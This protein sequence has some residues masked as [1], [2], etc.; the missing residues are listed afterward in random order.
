[1]IRPN[2]RL[3]FTASDMDFI[4]SVLGA[5]KDSSEHLRKLF[6]DPESLDAI[7]DDKRLLQQI[8]DHPNCLKISPRLYFYI[9][10]R[11]VLKKSGIDD[12]K[13]ADYT[14]ELLT[15]YARS[16]RSKRPI[17]TDGQPVKYFTDVMAAM[18]NADERMCFFIQLFV[19]NYSLFLSGIFPDYLRHRTQYKAAPR[20]EYYER[21]GSSN[22]RS[23]SN[24]LLARKYNLADILVRLSECFHNVRLALNDLSERLVFIKAS[25]V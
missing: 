16:D 23:A 10:V 18:E 4:I 11:H 7:L 21:L 8:L 14:A 6:A 5:R 19:G 25:V 17:A 1:M 2:C 15:E 13:I 20:I 3:Q 22:Y 9:L 24:H 12:T